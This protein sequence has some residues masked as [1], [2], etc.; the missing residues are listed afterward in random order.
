MTALGQVLRRLRASRSGVAVTEFALSL[1]LLMTAGMWGLETAN[2]A[3]VN[4]RVSQAALH[5]ADNA[6]R[7]GDTS[8]LQD[9]KIYESDLNDVLLGANLQAGGAID[10]FE[11]G[12]V[13]VSSLEVVEGTEDQQYI[14]WQRCKGVKA[15]ESAYGGEGHGLAGNLTGMGPEG[16]EVTAEPGEAVI[17]V[18]VSY[19]YQPLIGDVFTNTGE[20][21]T[22]AAFNVRDDRDLSQIYQRD[23]GSPDPAASCSVNDGFGATRG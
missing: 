6:S 20:I 19:D 22:T 4:M 10:L 8:T 7:I 14:H 16:E 3:I 23:G 5:I 21:T 2:L 15:F 18:E 13:I 12:R 9:R 17:F 11:H 1:P